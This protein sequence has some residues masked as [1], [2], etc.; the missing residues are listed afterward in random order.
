MDVNL[1]FDGRSG[2]DLK[3]MQDQL[4][5]SSTRRTGSTAGSK[6][7]RRPFNP[8]VGPGPL[9]IQP[10]IHH[11]FRKP[12]K[13]ASSFIALLFTAICLA[14]LGFLIIGVGGLDKS[15]FLIN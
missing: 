4:T 12:E 5:D 8:I 2:Q 10:E 13:R 14:P 1:M 15:N 6:L 9:K 11:Q 3:Q 7:A